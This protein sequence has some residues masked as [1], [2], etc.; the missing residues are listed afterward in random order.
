MKIR[1]NTL[2]KL[3]EEREKSKYKFHGYQKLIKCWFGKNLINK[4]YFQVED[5]VFKWDKTHELKGKHT[6]FHICGLVH[7]KF[8]KSWFFNFYIKTLEREIENLPINSQILKK[9]FS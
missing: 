9:Y 2:L 6:K 3:E 1:I 5:L 4:K 8:L 7:F